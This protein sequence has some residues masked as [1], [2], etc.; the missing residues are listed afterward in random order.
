[1]F[2]RQN[3]K[4]CLVSQ[5]NLVSNVGFGILGTFTKHDYSQFACLKLTQ[6]SSDLDYFELD[7]S[8]SA[9]YLKRIN[10]FLSEFK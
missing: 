9:E 6:N 2:Q 3:Q 8:Y 1:M 5:Q 10:L 4:K 7:E